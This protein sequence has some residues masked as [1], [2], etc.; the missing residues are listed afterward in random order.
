MPLSSAELLRFSANEPKRRRK[1][2]YVKQ[3]EFASLIIEKQRIA[4]KIKS[5]K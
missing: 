2:N 3:I 1:L 5:S 4:T